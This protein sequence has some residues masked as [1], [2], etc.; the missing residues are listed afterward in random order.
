MQDNKLV[1][2]PR[3]ST[4][5][6]ERRRESQRVSI[7][8]LTSAR[9]SNIPCRRPPF[10]LNRPYILSGIDSTHVARPHPESGRCRKDLVNREI[11]LC[12]CIS[13]GATWA[14]RTPMEMK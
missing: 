8:L 11:T 13:Y 3:R 12:M 6:P 14:A 1:G 5:S 2:L 4:R 7:I 10:L 9:N